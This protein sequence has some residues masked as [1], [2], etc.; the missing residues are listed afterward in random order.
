M[1]LDER[2]IFFDIVCSLMRIVKYTEHSFFSLGFNFHV[3]LDR[4]QKTE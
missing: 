2:K 1:E 3:T 4:L